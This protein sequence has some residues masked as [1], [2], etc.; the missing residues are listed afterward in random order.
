LFPWT[1]RIIMIIGS[2]CLLMF[3]SHVCAFSDLRI[4]TPTI[5]PVQVETKTKVKGQQSIQ[6]LQKSQYESALDGKWYKVVKWIFKDFILDCMTA[7]DSLLMVE[8]P[9]IR[10]GSFLYQLYKWPKG[11]LSAYAEDESYLKLFVDTWDGI[12]KGN[13]AYLIWQLRKQYVDV[14]GK[15][16]KVGGGFYRSS[17][18]RSRIN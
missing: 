1:A 14:K 13:E 5:E 3:S 17:S 2:W 7:I 18:N 16:K 6:N 11:G 15:R 10:A 8:E 4:E 12:D 9:E